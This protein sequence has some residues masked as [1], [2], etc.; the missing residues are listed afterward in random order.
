MNARSHARTHARRARHH[1]LEGPL[2]VVSSCCV[3]ATPASALCRHR[4]RHV[5]R[6]RIGRAVVWKRMLCHACLLQSV[7]MSMHMP[8]YTHM[9][10]YTHRCSACAGV[11]SSESCTRGTIAGGAQGIDLCTGMCIDV[12]PFAR[13]CTR[14]VR[15]VEWST[16]PSTSQERSPLYICRTTSL[17]TYT[18]TCICPHTYL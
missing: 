3:I 5:R 15:R 10:A 12:F 6:I 16:H 7:H 9:H 18:H 11:T 8:M 4:R 1:R 13:T 17:H 2:R 14:V